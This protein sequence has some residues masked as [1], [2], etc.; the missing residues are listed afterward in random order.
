MTSMIQIPGLSAQQ[1]ML[2]DLLWA[3]N[4]SQQVKALV[5]AMPPKWQQQCE[6]LIT[7]IQVTAV[8]H[9]DTVSHSVTQL[10]HDLSQRPTT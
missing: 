9:V 1:I 2:C 4:T 8:D 10:L 6:V 3:C 7:M 5:A